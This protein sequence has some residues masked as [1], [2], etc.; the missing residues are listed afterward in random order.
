MITLDERF[1]LGVTSWYG[2]NGLLG[3]GLAFLLGPGIGFSLP[4]VI[5][6]ISYRRYR[7]TPGA[8]ERCGYDMLLPPDRKRRLNICPECGWEVPRKQERSN[9]QDRKST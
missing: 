9:T 3:L 8:C 5:S 4:I 2:S 1:N 6:L 7:I